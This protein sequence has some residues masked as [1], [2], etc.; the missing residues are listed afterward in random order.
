MA[1][2]LYLAEQLIALPSVTP[3][4]AGCQALIAS[5]LEPLGFAC[6]HLPL[7]PD[8]FRV[9]NLWAIFKAKSGSRPS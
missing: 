4:D 5:R 7:G 8:N 9:A 1:N 6:H 2:T 3:Q